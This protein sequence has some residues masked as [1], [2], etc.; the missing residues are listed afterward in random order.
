MTSDD[1][2]ELLEAYQDMR[3]S[4][5]LELA[6]YKKHLA[7]LKRWP[8]SERALDPISRIDDWCKRSI[9]R[10][11]RDQVVRGHNN[12]VGAA[13]RMV[14]FYEKERDRTNRNILLI[15]REMEHRIPLRPRR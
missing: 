5:S 7:F 3:T 12:E 8:P 14:E 2:A 9:P 4:Y 15:S 6:S 11:M 1:L 13:T 10:K